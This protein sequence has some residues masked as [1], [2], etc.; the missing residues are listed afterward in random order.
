[1]PTLWRIDWAKAHCSIDRQYRLRRATCNS[2]CSKP[3]KTWLTFALRRA[4][5]FSWFL[6]SHVPGNPALIV[7]SAWPAFG[8]IS[9]ALTHSHAPFISTYCAFWNSVNDANSTLFRNRP[10]PEFR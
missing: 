3:D 1:M 9:A 8:A 7:Q 5:V 2:A 4:L 6:N 10:A